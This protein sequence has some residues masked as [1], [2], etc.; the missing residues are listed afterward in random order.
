MGWRQ[1]WD[2]HELIGLRLC[3]ILLGEVHGRDLRG[4]AADAVEWKGWEN[5]R[6]KWERKGVS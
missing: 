4:E 6:T 5:G 2:A 3:E 1:R